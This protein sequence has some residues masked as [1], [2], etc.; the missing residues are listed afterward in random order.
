MKHSALKRNSGVTFIE[1]MIVVVIVGILAGLAAPQYGAF[2]DRTS[3]L[4]ESRRITSLLKVARS[5]AR[6]RGTLVV[7]TGPADG[8]WA[9]E[10]IVKESAG[11][12]EVKISEGR[13]R[14]AVDTSFDTN[15][16][17]FNSRGW[18]DSSGPFTIGICTSATNNTHGRLI[19]VNRVGKITE[20]PLEDEASC[21]Q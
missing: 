1:L 15:S 7:I 12:E 17:T 19:S 8:N 6:S 9:G 4:S 20:G 11:D 3:L 16:V 18:V 14:V 10:L 21:A 13:G 2:I 5:E